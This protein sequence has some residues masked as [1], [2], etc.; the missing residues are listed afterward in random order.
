[1][2]EFTITGN[3]PSYGRTGILTTPHG[4]IKTPVFM[5]VGTVATVKSLT[6][7]DLECIGAQI[8]LANNYHLFLR[9]GPS[10]VKK[11]GGIHRFM[12]WSHPVLTDSGGFQLQSLSREKVNLC[13]ISE[14]GAEF[15]SHIDGS[16]HFLTPE[17]ATRS[18]MNIGADIIMAFDHSVPAGADYRHAID[19]TDRTHR[20]LIRSVREWQ[21]KKP[22]GTPQQA[23]FGIIQGGDFA[24]L[25]RYAA[26]FVIS[27]N[28]PGIAIGGASVG[29]D[30]SQ[31]TENIHF[32]RD[33]LP[34]NTPLYAMGVGIKPSDA[35]AVIKAG[36]DMFDCVAPTRLARCGQLYNLSEK[37]E[38]IDINQAKFR[39]D[40]KPVDSACDCYTCTG[41]TRAYLHHLFKSRELLYY[42]L[43]SLHNLRIMIK[44]V[45][46][47]AFPTA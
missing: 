14:T 1:M 21:N 40:K 42:R 15:R 22:G 16:T 23:L 26:E 37:K 27:Q 29:A 36:A 9:P 5:P 33:L 41:F 25:R 8:I 38:Y 13:K 17:S 30:T 31:T 10:A 18:Q 2:F 39:L 34:K 19:A 7:S 4:T 3:L 44:T 35:V 20:W 6:P 43:A 45:T 46:D 24:D 11:M 28:L 12:N 47:F 32:I